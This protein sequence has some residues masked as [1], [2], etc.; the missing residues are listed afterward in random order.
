MRLKTYWKL[1]QG[2]VR[3]DT[4]DEALEIMTRAS[5]ASVE[6]FLRLASHFAKDYGRLPDE[7]HNIVVLTGGEHAASYLKNLSGRTE[8]QGV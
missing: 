6:H 1:Y 7:L 2:Y 8:G 5:S 3:S 4:R